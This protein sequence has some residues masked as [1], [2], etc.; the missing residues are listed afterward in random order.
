MLD[1]RFNFLSEQFN[2][3][4]PKFYEITE[5]NHFW[6]YCILYTNQFPKL[7]SFVYNNIDN[8]EIYDKDINGNSLLFVSLIYKCVDKRIT[9]I[10]LNKGFDLSRNENK[11]FH[12]VFLVL[13]N[14]D[15][16]I[17]FFNCGLNINITNYKGNNLLIEFLESNIN[18]NENYLYDIVLFF[19]DN[20][21]NINHVNNLGNNALYYSLYHPK[22]TKL[23]IERG[24]I[25]VNFKNNR[26]NTSLMW[27]ISK[28]RINDKFYETMEII[29]DNNYDINHLNIYNEH[30]LNLT[31][32]LYITKTIFN[33]STKYGS[34]IT[35]MN[36]IVC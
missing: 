6:Y 1:Q 25:D 27:H 20:G 9:N 29:L 3:I 36:R 32:D 14:L 7:V 28:Y 31:N 17:K 18:K 5:N 26:L 12:E 21:I 13:N 19:L 23:L 8:D 30:I 35:K 2:K 15:L 4:V 11:L 22:I 16:L 10:I 34:W 24:G 33:Y